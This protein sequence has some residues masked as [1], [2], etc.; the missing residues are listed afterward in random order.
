ML[1]TVR[2]L[3]ALALP[4]ASFEC[5]PP[6]VADPAL[7][8][9]SYSY[10]QDGTPTTTWTVSP[11]C[12][13]VVG[14]LRDNLELPLGCVLHINS[15]A[16]NPSDEDKPG[17]IVAGGDA[18]LAGGLWSYTEPLGEGI[19]CPD[20]SVAKAI[21]TVS[22]DGDALTGTRKTLVDASACGGWRSPRDEP[23]LH[24]RVSG[25]IVGTHRALPPGLRTRRPSP[26]LLSRRRQPTRSFRSWYPVY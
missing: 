8:Q 9:G 23:S 26:L 2:Y 13:P 25:T 22:F 6:A 24:P 10:I 11:T 3:L 17:L 16:A 7:L 12:V 21:Q 1:K 15:I 4:I 19:T 14:D 5:A 20:G 18:R